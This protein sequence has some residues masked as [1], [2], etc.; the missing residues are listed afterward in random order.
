MVEKVIKIESV[1][2]TKTMVKA[3]DEFLLNCRGGM[4]LRKVLEKKIE[5]VDS[6]GLIYI[7]SNVFR[8]T[9]NVISFPVSS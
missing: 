3:R 9:S 8:S 5:P 7:Y 1:N 2:V 6:T 4:D